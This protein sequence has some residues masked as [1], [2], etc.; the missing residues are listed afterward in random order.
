MSSVQ[1]DC[2]RPNIGR[3]GFYNWLCIAKVDVVWEGNEKNCF[4][5]GVISLIP[6]DELKTL[7]ARV[8]DISIDVRCFHIRASENCRHFGEK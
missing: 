7:M 5:G 3:G 6:L 4:R 8:I 2:D 1:N